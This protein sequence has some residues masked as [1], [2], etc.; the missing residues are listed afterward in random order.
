MNECDISSCTP[1]NCCNFRT[2]T[3][4]LA[5]VQSRQSDDDSREEEDT[6]QQIEQNMVC[7]TRETDSSQPF[8]L[9][10]TIIFNNDN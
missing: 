9:S 7:V 1:N 6:V 3:T 2:T 8:E 5:L 10:D 4:E